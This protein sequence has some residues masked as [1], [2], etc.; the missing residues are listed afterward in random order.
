MKEIELIEKYKNIEDKIPSMFEDYYKAG[1]ELAY[2]LAYTW[3][4][5]NC[6]LIRVI[7]L[8]DLNTMNIYNLSK[9]IN[10]DFSFAGLYPHV[11]KTHN[12][13]NAE[14]K[15]VVDESIEKIINNK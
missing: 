7:V 3:N 15:R 13:D 12:I 2:D 4:I 8:I 10:Y 9:H 11:Q 5:G 6:E 14:L 1:S